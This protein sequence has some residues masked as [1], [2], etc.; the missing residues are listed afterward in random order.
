MASLAPAIALPL[1]HYLL[2]IDHSNYIFP[3]FGG[4]YGIA[5]IVA[6]CLYPKR[7]IETVGTAEITA[8]E[9]ASENIQY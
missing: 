5:A 1:F 4:C 8:R 9:T 2:N 3:I 7:R 6:A